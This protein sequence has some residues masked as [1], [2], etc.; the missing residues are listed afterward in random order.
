MLAPKA[1]ETQR[2]GPSHMSEKINRIIK[3]AE[4][5][6][7][8]GDLQKAR[9]SCIQGLEAHPNN[10]RLQAL[11]IRL[12]KPQA[13]Q[14]RGNGSQGDNL[15]H[16][17]VDELQNLAN[18]S[19]WLL[20][21][22]RCLELSDQH[23]GSAVLFNFLGCAQLQKGYPILAEAAFKKSIS[24][25]PAFFAGYT[26]LGN[27]LVAL[28]RFEE[29][30]EVHKTAAKLNPTHAQTQNN[31]GTLYEALAR[32]EEAYECFKKA[33]SLDPEYAT[34]HYNLAAV[35]L[36]FKNFKE[37]W[38]KREARWDRKANEEWMP[39]I[40]TDKP[41]WSGCKADR[42]YVWSEQGVGDEV[43]FASCFNDLL[44]KCNSLVVACNS[45]LLPL[46]Q[47]SFGQEIEFVDRIQGLPDTQFD[48]HAPALT[49]TGL[50][51]QD[52]KDFGSAAFPYLKAD[53]ALVESLRNSIA[54]VS[55]GRPIIGLSWFS[56]NKLTG[57]R[58]SISLVELV[59][60]LP[61]EFFLVNLQYGDVKEDLI[62]VERTLGRSV[63]NFNNIDNWN[64]IDV[65]AAL[66]GAC[67][68]VVSIDNSTVH[69]AGALGKECHVLLPFS[70]DWRWG[71]QCEERS[72]WYNS[73]LLHRQSELN[74]WGGAIGS[75]TS[76]LKENSPS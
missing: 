1:L 62:E 54:K 2:V 32:Y 39:P 70:T 9:L 36:R 47:R 38:S 28:E 26:N 66:I 15:P 8:F 25:D 27:A 14:H 60:S 55:A 50:V 4:K 43:M 46:F 40:Q 20:L 19:E 75:L 31:L 6:V 48:C 44:P 30:E 10:P 24:N 42:L 71:L 33:A 52:L 23:S 56:K 5:S 51:R 67:D 72:Y 7:K 18:S 65:F 12:S 53:P 73:L 64:D 69:F 22:K 29:A 49:A 61:K 57:R 37:G 59:S 3:S 68:K 34:A 13:S 58:R 17:I 45:R 76:A 21:A 16:I 63:A 41:L 35:N 74:D 11:A